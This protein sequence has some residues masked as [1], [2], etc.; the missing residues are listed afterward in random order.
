MPRKRRSDTGLRPSIRT[1]EGIP[2]RH[3]KPL[4]K[5]PKWQEYYRRAEVRAEHHTSVQRAAGWSDAPSCIYPN[6]NR[7]RL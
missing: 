4:L 1:T 6:H 3:A 2:G 5:T 7:E